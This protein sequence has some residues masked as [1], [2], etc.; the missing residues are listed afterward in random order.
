[1]ILLDYGDIYGS[2]YQIKF[3]GKDKYKTL[4][5][6]IL[7]FLTFLAVIL[8][9]YFLGTDMWL[10]QNPKIM[11]EIAIPDDFKD[12]DSSEKINNEKFTIAWRI[13][14]INGNTIDTSS[15]LFP[16]AK[17]IKSGQKIVSKNCLD[18]GKK[19]D[20][21]FKDVILKGDKIENWQCLDLYQDYSSARSMW[22]GQTNFEFNLNYCPDENLSSPICSSYDLLLKEFAEKTKYLNIFVPEYMFASKQ[23]NNPLQMGYT[24]YIRAI[25]INIIKTQT[26]IFRRVDLYRDDSYFVEESVKSSYLTKTHRKRSI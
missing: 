25:D 4:P 2:P 18:Y 11:T 9:F 15:Y 26:V 20:P 16:F 14:D 8:L 17:L 1:M 19:V 5:G 6:F 23:I 21:F 24:N 22:Q 10:R 13:Q 7:S 3:F 12:K